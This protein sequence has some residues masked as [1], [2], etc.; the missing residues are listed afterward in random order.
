[1][2]KPSRW[3]RRDATPQVYPDP[4]VGAAQPGEPSGRERRPSLRDATTS[5][6][7]RNAKQ[8]LSPISKN[9]G[10]HIVTRYRSQPPNSKNSRVPCNRVAVA[11]RHSYLPKTIRANSMSTNPTMISKNN[12]TMISTGS[13]FQHSFFPSPT[14]PGSLDRHTWAQQGRLRPHGCLR[15]RCQLV[16]C[17][18]RGQSSKPH[19]PTYGSQA[20]AKSVVQSADGVNMAAKAEDKPADSV[21]SRA[22]GSC[23]PLWSGSSRL[24]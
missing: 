16:L 17:E 22:N 12:V 13:S 3:E 4:E 21:S 15:L 7:G 2:S 24:F 20:S 14:G 1:M 6:P 5:R 18:S 19:C 23:F 11:P 8:P 9:S 10:K